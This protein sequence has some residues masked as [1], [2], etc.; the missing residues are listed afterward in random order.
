MCE[1]GPPK[2]RPECVTVTVCNVGMLTNACLTGATA[3]TIAATQDLLL[4]DMLRIYG[5]KF[6]N[7]FH[8][9]EVL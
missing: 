6:D 4:R 5:R 2:G 9:P 8:I 1:K 7:R 3:L